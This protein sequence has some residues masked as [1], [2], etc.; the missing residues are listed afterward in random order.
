MFNNVEEIVEVLLKHNYLLDYKLAV[1]IYLADKINKPVLIEGPA[2]VGKTE[3]GKKIA[4]AK[5]LQFIR[6]Q[7]YEGLDESKALYEWNYQKQLLCIESLKFKD[8]WHQIQKDI[9]TYDFLLPRPILKAL[10]SNKKVV[11]LIDEVDK[12]DEEF[13]SFLL[14]ALSDFQ[15]TI[16]EYDTVSAKIKPLVIITSNNRRNLS[17]ALKRRCLHLYIDFPDFEREKEIIK[18]KVPEINEKLNEKLVSFV[19]SLRQMD[20]RKCPSVSETIDWA[21]SLIILKVKELDKESVIN[22]LNILLKYKSDVEKVEKR[23]SVMLT[24]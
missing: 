20:L 23:L 21:K 10:T 13:E 4:E 12:S 1:P 7:C 9:Y 24:G 16:P 17:D 15:I 5:E 14:E 11:L 8:S 18:K 2:G 3:L 22:T 19:Q 6:L